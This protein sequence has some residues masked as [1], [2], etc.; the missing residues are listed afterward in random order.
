MKTHTL[1]RSAPSFFPAREGRHLWPA[2]ASSMVALAWAASVAWMA[3][4]G[5]SQGGRP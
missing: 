5:Q 4:L 3:G 1:N 2:K